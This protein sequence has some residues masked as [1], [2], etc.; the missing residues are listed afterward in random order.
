MDRPM[1]ITPPQLLNLIGQS[2]VSIVDLADQ[3]KY[4]G[5]HIPGAVHLAYEK[6]VDE[7]PPVAGFLPD[8][9]RFSQVLENLGITRGTYVIAYDENGGGTAGRFLWMLDVVGHPRFALLDGG[10]G[11]WI[12]EGHP[13]NNDRP[14]AQAGHYAASYN[15]EMLANKRYILTHLADPNIV[16]LDTRSD[17]EYLGTIK[18]AQRGGH[19]PGAVHLEWSRTLEQHNNHRIRSQQE[20]RPLFE[21]LG[22]TPDKEIITYCQSHRRAAHTYLILKSLGYPQVKGY[23]GSWSEWGNCDDTP[24]EVG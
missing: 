18:R 17:E 4:H 13:V 5:A 21:V 20:L 24:I 6:L 9:G 7:Q 15:D 22:A 23:A 8:S 2:D 19:I 14:D 16:L 11:A 12:N 10:L 1:L 3:G